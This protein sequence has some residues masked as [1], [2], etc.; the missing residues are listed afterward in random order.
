[1]N[2][3][4]LFHSFYPT[5][6]RP[7]PLISR[8]VLLNIIVSRLKW[9]NYFNLNNFLWFIYNIFTLILTLYLWWRDL[10]RETTFLGIINHTIY[11]NLRFGIYL[12]ILS[13]VLFFVSFFWTYFHFALAPD[14][15]IG[16]IWPPKGIQIFN[17]YDIPFLN[18]VILITSGFS[19]TLSHY[20]LINRNIKSRI[21]NLIFTIFLGLYFSILQGYEYYEATFSIRDSCYGSSFFIITGFHGVHVIIGTIFLIIQLIRIKLIHISSYC[22]LGFES[23]S[24]YWHFVDVV[25]L[26]LYINL[27]WWRY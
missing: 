20:C 24:W 13:E 21:S 23:A 11:A 3:K 26:F 5:S 25:W 12:F 16:I 17:P 8:I 10:V 9:I 6:I 27:Y 7:W 15:T 22:H 14:I 2:K 19:V 4:N 1:M 18:S